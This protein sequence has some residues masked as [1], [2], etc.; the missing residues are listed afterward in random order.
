[1]KQIK[2]KKLLK[3]INAC[4]LGVCLLTS[5]KKDKVLAGTDKELFDMAKTTAGFV[6]YKNSSAL[7]DKSGGSGHP[8]PF[9]KTRYNAIAATQL[10]TTGKIIAGSTFPEG[11]LIVKELYDNATKLGRYAIL[12]KKSASEDADSNGW[13]WGYIDADGSVAVPASQK[14]T[15]CINCHS[16]ADNID[17]MLM[18][19]F[20]P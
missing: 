14:G 18:N 17:Y 3:T 11:S 7:L 12:Y 6:W 16:Q 9:L 10:D 19:K 4:L 20:F 8:Q 5:C 2:N 13:I 15:S 1:M